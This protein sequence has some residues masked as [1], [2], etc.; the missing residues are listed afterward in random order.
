MYCLGLGFCLRA[1][2]ERGLLLNWGVLPGLVVRCLELLEVWYRSLHPAAQS[3]QFHRV[4]V[5]YWGNARD[6]GSWVV[7]WWK[8]NKY[9]IEITYSVDNSFCYL[10]PWFFVV[11]FCC[12]F[13]LKNY[14]Y[15][16]LA[17]RKGVS[18]LDNIG[19]NVDKR[20]S[21]LWL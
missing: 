6:L 21:P 10:L 17:Q 7:F 9:I 3:D 19:I 1:R 5:I 20:D 11:T 18:F 2:L 13:C 8:I 14:L 4:V 16:S 15:I 12:N